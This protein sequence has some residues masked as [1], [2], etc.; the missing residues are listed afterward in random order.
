MAQQVS[1]QSYLQCKAL[2]FFFTEYNDDCWEWL[3]QDLDTPY[4]FDYDQVISKKFELEPMENIKS[5]VQDLY[6]LF[7]EVEA[8]GYK[9]ALNEG[10]PEYDTNS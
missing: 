9:R 7:K 3:A 5:M 6:A 10:D 1:K 2:D 8:S 4:A